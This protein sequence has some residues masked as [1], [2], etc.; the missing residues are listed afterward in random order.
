MKTAYAVSTPTLAFSSLATSNRLLCGTDS[1]T[2]RYVCAKSQ[3]P[4]TVTNPQ[5]VLLG[6]E[7]ATSCDD[8]LLSHRN[9]RCCKGQRYAEAH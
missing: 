1:K 5:G 6:G 2:Q 3:T 8:E 4:P 9:G 7:H